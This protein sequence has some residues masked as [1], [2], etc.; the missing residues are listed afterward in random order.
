MAHIVQGKISQWNIDGET[1]LAALMIR[2]RVAL[3]QAKLPSWAYPFSYAEARSVIAGSVS[4]AERG[5]TI[6]NV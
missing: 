2:F 6:L 5:I 4:R 3:C 1:E